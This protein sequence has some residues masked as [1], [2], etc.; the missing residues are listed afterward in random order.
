MH[1]AFLFSGLSTESSELHFVP[2]ETVCTVCTAL[3]GKHTLS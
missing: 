1:E 2:P 3:N